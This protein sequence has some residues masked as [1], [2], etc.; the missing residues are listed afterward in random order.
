MSAKYP[1]IGRSNEL[2]QRARQV[3][4]RTGNLLARSPTQWSD[5]VAPKFIDRGRGGR[6]WDVDENE[7]VDLS[8]GVGPV[9]L[10]YADPRVDAAIREQLERGIIFSLMSPLEV[11]VAELLRE[12]VPGAERVRFAKTGADV[13]SAAI[14]LARAYT[15]RSVVLTCGYHGWHDWYVATTDRNRGVPTEVAR[16]TFTF[17]YD[18]LASLE[19][20]LDGDVAAVILEPVVFDPPSPGFLEGVRA[21]CDRHGSVL[22]FD[23]MWTG[24]RLGL[25][26]A[27]EYFG[28][29]ADL[30]CFSKA[31][32]NGMP[33][34][35]LSGRRELIEQTDRD[36]FFFTTFAGESLSLAAAK[37]TLDTM[38]T[39][40][41]FADLRRIGSELQKGYNELARSAGADFTSCDGHPSRTCVRFVAHNGVAPLDMKTFVQQELLARGVLWSGHHTVCRAHDARDIEQVLDAYRE[42]LPLLK[43]H[44]AAGNLRRHLRGEPVEASFRKSEGF[45]TRPRR[46]A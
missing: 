17:D 23:E 2:W 27:Q 26:G 36:V 29:R 3:M 42:V 35:V 6:C 25:G 30:A 24:F 21:L 39:E 15:G 41:V 33:L 13:T 45:H 37:A 44:V 1:S 5:G 4:P 16:Q 34:S 38:M 46:S 31:I 18:D 32:A 14:R 8:M 11:E 20:S 19:A 40:P 7:Y 12:A 28:V 43:E 22:I 10:G 9:S